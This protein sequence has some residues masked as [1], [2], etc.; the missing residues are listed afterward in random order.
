MMDDVLFDI[1]SDSS[2]EQRHLLATLKNSSKGGP[3]KG[4]PG[5]KGYVK[6][7]AVICIMQLCG[8]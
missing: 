3:A 2:P 7:G 4:E 8:R 5:I 1:D 6:Q